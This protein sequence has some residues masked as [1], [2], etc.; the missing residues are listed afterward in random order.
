MIIK[1]GNFFVVEPAEKPLNSGHVVFKLGRR[2]PEL[3]DEELKE[4]SEALIQIVSK[5]KD[6]YKPEGY[7]VL[8]FE[9]AVEVVPRWC[10]DISFNALMGLKTTPQTPRMIY[11]ALK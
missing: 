5:I 2:I 7:N 6:V 3:S 1:K 8:L 10:G 4:L 11:D 9:D